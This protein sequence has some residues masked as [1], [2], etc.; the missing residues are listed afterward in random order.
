MKFKLLPILLTVLLVSCKKKIVSEDIAKINGYWEIEKVILPNG[1][2]KDYTANTTVDYFEI[3]GNAGI[4]K[5]VT[6]LLD[7]KFSGNGHQEKVAVVKKDGKTYLD[8]AT[9]YAKWEEELITIG[10]STFIVRNKQKLEYHYK[11]YKPFT[12]K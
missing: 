8:Y 2:K 10:D 5:K 6:P 4:R 7:G 9:E 1:Q 3:S 11:K 12:L